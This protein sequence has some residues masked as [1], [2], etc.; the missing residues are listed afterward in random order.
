MRVLKA[1]PPNYSAI[2]KAFPQIKGKPGI[3]YAYGDTLYNPSSAGVTPWIIAH[4]SIHMAR[5]ELV[6]VEAWWAEYIKD[7]TY[8]IAEEILAHRAEY[9]RFRELMGYGK[10]LDEYLDHTIIPRLSGPL[11][12]KLLT[13][14]QAREEIV[15]DR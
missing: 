1:F 12:G 8:R 9:N 14:A 2:R 10:A 3:L 6:G 4:E 13:P 11:Y 5:Q 15:Y 7:P